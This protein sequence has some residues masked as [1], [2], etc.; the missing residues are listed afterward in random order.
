MEDLSDVDVDLGDH[1]R[2]QEGRHW[3]GFSRD[4]VR[5]IRAH[6]RQIRCWSIRCRSGCLL[7]GLG[8]CR[9]FIQADALGGISQKALGV[10]PVVAPLRVHQ[11]IHEAQISEGITAVDHLAVVNLAAVLIH[12]ARRQGRTAEDHRNIDARIVEGLEVV[13]HESR[14]FH[15]QTAHGDAIGLMLTLG[16]NDRV[17]ALLDAEVDHLKAVVGEDDVHQVLADVVDITLHRGDQELALARALTLAFF[18]VRLEVSHGGFHRLGALQH[19]GELHLAAAEQFTHHLHAIEQKGVDDLQ[20]GIGLQRLVQ[21]GLKADA[22]PI[23][24][25]LLEPFLNRQIGQ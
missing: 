23:N 18:H 4:G 9:L 12:E 24:D 20:R 21:G 6:R 10:A 8:G 16:L 17:T 11:R 14:G 2:T 1:S 25:V 5:T 13:L 22:L 15:Q 3:C 19:E 7:S